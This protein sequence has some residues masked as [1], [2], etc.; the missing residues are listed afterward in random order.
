MKK[1]IAVVLFL[2][3]V[4]A[5]S[6]WA[7]EPVAEGTASEPSKWSKAGGEISEAAGAVGEATVDTSKKAWKT[8]KE[9]STEAW[10]ATKEGSKEAWEATK[11]GSAEALDKTKS[12]TKELWEKGKAKLHDATAPDSSKTATE[13]E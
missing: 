8:T 9:G 3:M 12:K 6:V 13:T 4:G 1:M 2:G 7:S 5:A 10:E 11:E